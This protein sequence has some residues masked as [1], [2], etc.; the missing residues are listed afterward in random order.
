MD[1]SRT[2]LSSRQKYPIKLVNAKEDIFC[3]TLDRP[4]DTIVTYGK[5]YEHDPMV[6]RSSMLPYYGCGMLTRIAERT[7]TRGLTCG[8]N[9]ISSMADC[10]MM[11]VVFTSDMLR[12][13]EGG[14][15]GDL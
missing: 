8:R 13:A 1:G 15:F 3:L 5:E 7:E 4:I 9:S 11:L 6:K 12:G 2:D 14:R 10:L